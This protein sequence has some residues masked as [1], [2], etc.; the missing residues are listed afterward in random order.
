M[1]VDLASVDSP[2]AD[3]DNDAD[4]HQVDKALALAIEDR[5]E[6]LDLLVRREHLM[7]LG[8]FLVLD[9][10]LGVGSSDLVVMLV[11]LELQSLLSLEESELVDSEKS[12]ETADSTDCC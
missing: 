12:L 9:P 1:A 6:S 2:A 10:T 8:S 7:V 11:L 3:A 4:N 5:Q